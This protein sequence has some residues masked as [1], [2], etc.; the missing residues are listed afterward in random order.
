M[1]PFDVVVVVE[2]EWVVV[3]GSR[4][5]RGSSKD[6]AAVETLETAPLPLGRTTTTRNTVALSSLCGCCCWWRQADA[7]VAA[8]QGRHP[9]WLSSRTLAQSSQTDKKATKKMQPVVGLVEVVEDDDDG[10]AGEKSGYLLSSTTKTTS[11]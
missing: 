6:D 3:D 4:M 1:A 10:V 8:V 11:H 9:P 7:E 2:H 5:C